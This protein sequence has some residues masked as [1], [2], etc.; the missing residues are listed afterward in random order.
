MNLFHPAAYH[1][2]YAPG[3]VA[4]SKADADTAVGRAWLDALCAD[5]ATRTRI[6]R[7]RSYARS[8]ETTELSVSIGQHS[9]HYR[10]SWQG[11]FGSLRC[12]FDEGEETWEERGRGAVSVTVDIPCMP[13][14]QWREMTAIARALPLK[15]AQLSGAAITERLLTE[16]ERHGLSL[17]PSP[18]ELYVTCGCS[19][20]SKVCR[21]A[22]AALLQAA[23]VLDRD[24]LVLLLLRGRAAMDFLAGVADPDHASLRRTFRAGAPV[25]LPG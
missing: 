3:P 7:G 13:P 11:Q 10:A 6:V 2:T 14:E 1:R 16:T 4:A 22:A 20:R 18:H 24:P 17:L 21:H 5:P 23:Q 25:E 19:A 8:T 15:W 12:V 9:F